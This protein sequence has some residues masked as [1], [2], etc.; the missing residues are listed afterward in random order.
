MR[1]RFLAFALVIIAPASL[2]QAQVLLPESR[3][4]EPKKRPNLGLMPT[5]PTVQPKD[6]E[7][8]ERPTLY[9]KP[10]KEVTTPTNSWQAPA[11]TNYSKQQPS[12]ALTS[13]PRTTKSKLSPRTT[14][15]KSFDE[16]VAEIG[17]APT[18]IHK[19][20]PNN[21]SEL[22]NMQANT[23]QLTKKH[24]KEA[25]EKIRSVIEKYKMNTETRGRKNASFN[26]GGVVLESQSSRNKQAK[27]YRKKS[28]EEQ[29]MDRLAISIR[30]KR[31][32]KKYAN[33]KPT[34]VSDEQP[35]SWPSDEEYENSIKVVSSP[36]YIWGD[37]DLRIIKRALGYNSNVVSQK[38]QLRHR[39][40]LYTDSDIKT[41]PEE[42]WGGS[43]RVTKYDGKLKS[44]RFRSSAVCIP[45]KTLPKSIGSIRRVMGKY[46][47]NLVGTGNCS[48]NTTFRQNSITATYKGNG[49]VVCSF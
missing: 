33:M 21:I 27:T 37:K 23:S 48:T 17:K 16:I 8:K 32:A 12:P 4:N 20:L 1:L 6:S 49:E 26:P 7:E 42:L 35:P 44:I 18:Q 40:L 13:F 31:E 14:E 45:P 36:K 30:E 22:R 25:I 43:S 29:K 9:V 28:A 38:C 47:V 34:V 39:I 5:L 11:P 19:Q 3:S 15:R 2:V 10:K 41:Y 46:S 24:S